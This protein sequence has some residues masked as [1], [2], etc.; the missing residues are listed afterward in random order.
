MQ[1]RLF[2]TYRVFMIYFAVVG[3]IITMISFAV[4]GTIT[5]PIKRLTESVK[6]IGHGDFDRKIEVDTKDEV[7]V[8][9]ERFNEMQDNLKVYMDN[10]KKVTPKRN[11]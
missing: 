4:S 6:A 10:I 1:T 9:G 7:G 5:N 3:I 11:V 8:L 2:Y